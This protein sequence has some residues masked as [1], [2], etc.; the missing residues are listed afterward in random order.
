MNL[1]RLLI[2]Q[3]HDGFCA[4]NMWMFLL[5]ETSPMQKYDRQ[6]IKN[7]VIAIV[8]PLFDFLTVVKRGDI[9]KG[10]EYIRMRVVDEKSFKRGDKKLFQEF[11]DG[12]FRKTW[13]REKLIEMFNYND[14]DDWRR[15]MCEFVCVTY[16]C[17][18]VNVF[19]MRLILIWYRILQ[20]SKNKKCDGAL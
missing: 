12:Y 2:I 11:L 10:V 7:D 5:L 13:L 3:S 1:N 14:G 18:S 6:G 19:C 4:I 8:L 20:T 9:E 15:E 16:V 17:V